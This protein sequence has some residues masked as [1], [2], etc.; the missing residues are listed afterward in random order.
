MPDYAISRRKDTDISRIV[1]EKNCG[2]K[3]NVFRLHTS[4]KS[5]T[6]ARHYVYMSEKREKPALIHIVSP[7]SVAALRMQHHQV[8]P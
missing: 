2:N 5:S 4:K 3:N 8:R 6:F 1:Q 7:L